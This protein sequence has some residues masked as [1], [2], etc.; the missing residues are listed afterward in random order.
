MDDGIVVV[1]DRRTGWFETPREH[2]AQVIERQEGESRR[3][4]PA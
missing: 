4:C 1:R 3:W 2:A